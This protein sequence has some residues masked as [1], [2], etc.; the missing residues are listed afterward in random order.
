MKTSTR[1]LRLTAATAAALVLMTGAAQARPLVGNGPAE[2]AQTT[3]AYAGTY[4]PVAPANNVALA[5]DR[6][7]RI[8]VAPRITPLGNVPDRVDKLGTAAQRRM[9]AP[10]R[11]DA[12]IVHST[13]T[14]GGFDWTAAGIGAGIAILIVAVLGAGG[15][16][17]RGRRRIAL[18][19]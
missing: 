4:Q 3:Q 17:V 5:P 9:S 12:V 7:D 13:S 14:N 6:V 19:H 18:S 15:M 1:T 2:K 8:G 16:T 11:G 10:V